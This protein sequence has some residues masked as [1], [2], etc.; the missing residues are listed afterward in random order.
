[1]ITKVGWYKDIKSVRKASFF[2]Y[3]LKEIGA[4]APKKANVDCNEHFIKS[5]S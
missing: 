5:N 4:W 2:F 1:M 3:L